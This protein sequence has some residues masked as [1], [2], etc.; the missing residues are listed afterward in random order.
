V[1]EE[2]KGMS[3]GTF[4]VALAVGAALLAMW[5]QAR[6]P[7]LAPVALGGTMLHA[8]VAFALLTWATHGSDSSVVTLAAIFLGLLPA[9]V[10]ALVCTLWVLKAAQTAFD[11]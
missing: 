2:E 6:F 8:V 7:S 4:V 11:R 1:L 5:V 3:N 10:Y 9:L